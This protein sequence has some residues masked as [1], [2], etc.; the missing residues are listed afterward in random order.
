MS[1]IEAVALSIGEVTALVVGRVAGKTFDL[2][3]VKTKHLGENVVL[4]MHF[5]AAILVTF[6][7]S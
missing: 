1:V 3:P 4:G 2:K 5:G 6:I 7:Y